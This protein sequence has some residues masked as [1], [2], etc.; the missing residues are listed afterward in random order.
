MN[1][2]AREE[3]LYGAFEDLQCRLS[4]VLCHMGQLLCGCYRLLV[5][6]CGNI[7]F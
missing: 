7:L 5:R 2:G 4:S 6:L 1:P 3:L